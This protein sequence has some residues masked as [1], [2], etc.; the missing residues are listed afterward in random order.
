MN[1]MFRFR[2]G[3]RSTVLN[4]NFQALSRLLE[5]IIQYCIRWKN[6]FNIYYNLSYIK[7]RT[8]SSAS[9]S[10]NDKYNI[11]VPSYCNIA[12]VVQMLEVL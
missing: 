10:V 2:I 11:E 9:K 7:Y 3:T 4:I 12:Y 5:P 1:Q 6:S 8:A